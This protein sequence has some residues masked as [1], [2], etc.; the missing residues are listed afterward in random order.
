MR[1]FLKGLELDSETIDSIMAE[2]GKNVTGLKEQLQ[3]Y[4]A[5]VTDYEAKVTEL[6]G[7][8]ESNKK[9]LENLETLTN[10]NK[11]LKADAQLRDTKVKKEFSKFV[12][13]EV[14]DKVND[15]V[16]FATALEDYKKENPQYF[17]ETVVV[18]TQTAPNLSNGQTPPT[19]SSIMNDLIRGVN[20]RNN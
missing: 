17:G 9:S 11:T 19:T 16:D 14:M 20:N 8:I 18:K 6:N 12:R 1:E 2:Y 13:S 5:K 10:E 3:E 7:T 15:K 4:K